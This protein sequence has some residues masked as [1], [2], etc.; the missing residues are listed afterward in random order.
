MEE[1]LSIGA[2]AERS[3]VAPSALRYY[4]G[5]GAH[6][7]EPHRQ[8]TPPLPPGRPAPGRVHPV[9]QQV[10]PTLHEIRSA[11]ATLRDA[12]TPHK[13]DR[14]RL[15]N[16]WRPRIDEQIVQLERM[17]DRLTGCIGCGSLSLQVCKMLNPGDE[18]AAH[19]PGP[20]YVIESD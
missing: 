18:V 9:A 6:H 2:V 4:E 11:L 1:E 20:R 15:S 13:R 16:A 19:G 14:E 17:R 10:G 3:G 12:R 5:G 7:L 8:R